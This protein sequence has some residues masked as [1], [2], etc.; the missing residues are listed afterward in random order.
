M[1]TLADADRLRDEAPAKAVELYARL[2]SQIGPRDGDRLGWLARCRGLPQELAGIFR[3]GLQL[4]GSRVRLACA[5]A[6]GSLARNRGDTGDAER[7]YTRAFAEAP[8]GV[9][10]DLRLRAGA[11]LAQVYRTTQRVFEALLLARH[12]AAEADRVG[13]LPARAAAWLHVVGAYN[14]ILEPA[15][16]ASALERFGA[17][18]RDLDRPWAKTLRALHYGYAAQLAHATGDPEAA[19]EQLDGFLEIAEAEPELK[20]YALEAH[21]HRASRLIEMGELED[22]DESLRRARAGQ[23]SRPDFDI[24]IETVAAH[25][26][27][28]RD[29]NA[30]ARQR[31]RDLLDELRAKRDVLGTGAVLR[32]ATDLVALSVAGS[33][34]D[35]EARALEAQMASE[36]V[37][38]IERCLDHLPAPVEATDD[39]LALL[40]QQRERLEQLAQ[41]A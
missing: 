32:F 26:T 15:R 35:E 40:R 10:D 18:V 39:D 20:P 9:D 34:E 28:K 14:D 4:G 13:H 12:V 29:G 7:W 25:L 36:R 38:E 23:L 24:L 3:G 8:P 22:A 6:L 37:A 19:L 17:A 30:A 5:Y 2:R 11:N 41:H 1:P 27:A 16:M 33:A 31:V 21:V